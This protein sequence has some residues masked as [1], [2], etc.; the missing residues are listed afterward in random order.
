LANRIVLEDAPINMDELRQAMQHHY[1]SFSPR[2]RQVAELL[3]RDPQH[4]AIVA[5]R[6]L[7]AELHVPPSTLT[8]FAKVLGFATFKEVQALFKDHYVARPR[9]YLQRVKQAQWAQAD[10]QGHDGLH[11]DLVHAVQHSL[12]MT[13]LE[14]SRAKLQEAAQLLAGATEI[15][16]HGVRRAYPV[17]V[18]LQYLL[19]KVGAHASLLDAGG[20]FLEPSLSRLRAGGVL[21]VVTY[22]PHAPE[23]EAVMAAA[24]RADVK[25]IAFTDPLPSAYAKDMAIRFE[26]R[27]GE[28]MGFRA[29]SASMYVAQALVMELA[30]RLAGA[31]GR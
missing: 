21:L 28:V 10:S 13:S 31:P 22:S 30:Q 27:E 3:M 16:V 2:L 4:V 18:Y 9:D 14:V 8:R 12:H 19:L 25:M 29:L 5:L 11:V 24:R 26:I 15:W 6:E 7:A 17:A 23:T 1:D 20:G